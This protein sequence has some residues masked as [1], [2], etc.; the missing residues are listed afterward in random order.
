ML[1]LL[2]PVSLYVPWVQR[3]V[4]NRTL[5]VLNDNPDNLHYDIGSLQLRFPLEIELWDVCLSK[6]QGT[7]TANDTLVYVHHLHTAL[8]QFPWGEQTDYVVGQILVEGVQTGID[9]SFVT[10]LDLHGC[11]GGTGHYGKC[12]MASGV[13]C[14]S[15]GGPRFPLRPMAGGFAQPRA[16]ETPVGR[17][18]LR[19]RY[20]D[21]AFAPFAYRPFTCF[22]PLVFER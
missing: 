3:M 19:H 12:S 21:P 14:A 1:I 8:D 20:L 5:S 6:G 22:R 15:G 4:V 13:R 9:S 11:G 2:V 7:T 16:G 10:G 18:A 17:H